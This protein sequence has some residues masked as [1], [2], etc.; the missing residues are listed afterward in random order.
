MGSEMNTSEIIQALLPVAEALEKLSTNY[1]LGGSIASSLY[2]QA[3]PTQDID[4]VADLQPIHVKHF[5]ALLNQGYYID[6]ESILDA[7]RHKA[8]FNVIHLDLG[9]K[10]DIF[11]PTPRAFDQDELQRVQH[12]PLESGGRTFPVKAP[13]VLVLRK[14]E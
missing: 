13:E 3:R 9:M 8:S 14:L 4:L 1:H 7:I 6:E 12:L 11:I 5:V 10:I 2:G